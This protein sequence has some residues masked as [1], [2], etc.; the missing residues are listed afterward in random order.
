MTL[1][2]VRWPLL[3]YMSLRFSLVTLGL[4]S[5][6]IMKRIDAATLCLLEY[7][8]LSESKPSSPSVIAGQEKVA[9]AFEKMRRACV[10]TLGCD[11]IFQQLRNGT[12]SLLERIVDAYESLLQVC[13]LRFV[14]ANLVLTL[15]CNRVRPSRTKRSPPPL[16]LLWTRS[17][18]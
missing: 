11:S 13:A 15:F 2:T 7:R 18:I 10:K 4:E 9:R 17:S 5:A 8:E 12:R 16:W 1:Q 3:R 6:D 14:S